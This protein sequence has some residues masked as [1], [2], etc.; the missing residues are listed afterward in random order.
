MNPPV[1]KALKTE[2]FKMITRKSRTER[3]EIKKHEGFVEAALEEHRRH[4][5][6]KF[7]S[8]PFDL[9]G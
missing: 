5:S 2:E 3:W 7:G 9:D 1:L 6:E 4:F 8:L